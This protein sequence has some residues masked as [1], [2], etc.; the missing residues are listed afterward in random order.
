MLYGIYTVNY[1]TRLPL[2]PVERIAR[3]LDFEY[4]YADFESDDLDT[5][6]EV[7]KNEF[8]DK[9]YKK[10]SDIGKYGES[11]CFLCYVVRNDGTPIATVDFDKTIKMI[12]VEGN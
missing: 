11:E 9:V 6:L 8:A 1:W 5:I 4:G 2:K 12:N 7:V 10:F 3:W